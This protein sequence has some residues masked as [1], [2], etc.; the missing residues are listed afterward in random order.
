MNMRF[1]RY[2]LVRL[3]L[4]ALALVMVF[5]V[6]ASACQDCFLIQIPDYPWQAWT[7]GPV[8]LGPGYTGCLHDYYG[9]YCQTYGDPCQGGGPSCFLAGTMISTPDGDRP[10]ESLE[11]GDAIWCIA[12]DGRRVAGE[13]TQ[14]MRHVSSGYY[15]LNGSTMVTGAHRFLVVGSDPSF[16][17]TLAATQYQQHEHYQQ[18]ALGQWIPLEDIAPGQQLL[19]IDGGMVTVETME[20]VDRGVRVYNLEV[21][22]H[23]NYFADGILVH[24]RKPD[25]QG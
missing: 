17:V 20:F 25:P 4:F 14:T 8:T 5:A 1:S 10:I 15:R 12:D 23:H 9:F 24:N 21:A 16:G 3:G 7:C 13:I 6:S 18:H 19:T 22:P 2:S 11:E